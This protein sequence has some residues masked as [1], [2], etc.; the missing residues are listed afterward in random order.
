MQSKC[1]LSTAHFRAA[2]LLPRSPSVTSRPQ[3]NIL[4]R[5]FNRGMELSDDLRD[6]AT[7]YASEQELAELAFPTVIL[8]TEQVLSPFFSERC[9]HE[10]EA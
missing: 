8:S 5:A 1:S 7:Q 9:E 4:A 10:K 6:P 3:S 2:V